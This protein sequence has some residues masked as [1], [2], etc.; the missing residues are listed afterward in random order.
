MSMSTKT[1]KSDLKRKLFSSSVA[2]TVLH[3]ELFVQRAT[4]VA[5]FTSGPN[6]LLD[7]TPMTSGDLLLMVVQKSGEPKTHLGCIYKPL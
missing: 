3:S 2:A 7:R 4:V 5:R 6:H 1:L